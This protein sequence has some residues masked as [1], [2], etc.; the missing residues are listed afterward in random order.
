MR[1][2]VAFLGG[3]LLAAAAFAAY[4][5]IDAWAAR[6]P[7]LL[8]G[9]Q[10]PPRS[11]SLESWLTRRARAISARRATLLVDSGSFEVSFAEL[12]LSLDVEATAARARAA[13]RNPNL[14]ARLHAVLAPSPALDDVPL[15]FRFDDE[16]AAKYMA[17][18][19]PS[20]H[21]DP[22]DAR[23][24]LSAHAR[25]E[26]QP[27]REL[28]LR[29]SLLAIA[30]GERTDSAVFA[31]STRPIAARVTSDMLRQI[32][33]SRVLSSYETDFAHH[34]G[35]RAINIATAARYL[36]GTIIA[37]GETFSF[38]KTVGART[39]ERGFTF[40]PVIVADELEPG[41]GGGVCQVAS[42]LHAA[43]VFAGFDVVQRRSHSRPSGYAPLGLDAT[44][45]DGELDLKLRNPYDTALIIH[46]FLPTHSTLR[47]ELLGREPP[48]KVE[49]FAEV[50]EKHEFVRRIVV[51]PGF[52]P[53]QSKRHQKGIR[54]YDVLST[55]RTTYPDGQRR[56]HTYTSTYY[57]V[58]EVYWVG[59]GTD[60]SALPALPDG[61]QGIE[62]GDEAP[63]RLE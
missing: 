59:P 25:L 35:P 4:P 55:V 29:A 44:V 6:E 56:F 49:H 62:Y 53:N 9:G 1:I 19:A 26:D 14:V 54:G 3:G 58:P 20:L 41:V 13:E 15:A 42:T 51:E 48:G 46:A 34:G 2:W 18:L 63:T 5:R 40:A 32:D 30:R 12:G 38:N 16:R 10:V 17:A 31:I 50:K 60:V 24:D 45:I 36:N 37:P 33:V 21:R 27:G 28:D 43:A 22:V 57:P 47:V 11:E 61:A 8:V 52:G 23:L 39:V 7:S